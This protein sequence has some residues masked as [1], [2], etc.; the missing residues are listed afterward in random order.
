MSDEPQDLCCPSTSFTLFTLLPKPLSS[1]QTL[2]FF[3]C[4]CLFRSGP[5][6]RPSKFQ[7]SCPRLADTAMQAYLMNEFYCLATVLRRHNRDSKP[8][9]KWLDSPPL[10]GACTFC[11]L[12]IFVSLVYILSSHWGTATSWLQ[13]TGQIDEARAGGVD[14]LI[15]L[16]ARP[17]DL[18]DITLP[19]LEISWALPALKY[20]WLDLRDLMSL[21][22]RPGCSSEFCSLW[23]ASATLQ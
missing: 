9:S 21:D 6:C 22:S 19:S 18:F 7:L 13:I 16:T 15:R 2:P 11:V 8:L 17:A 20:G 1:F 12:F 4:L 14:Q 10:S 23:I 5:G 3:S